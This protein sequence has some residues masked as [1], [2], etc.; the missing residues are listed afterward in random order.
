MRTFIQAKLHLWVC[1]AIFVLLYVYIM[2][3]FE[4]IVKSH[5]EI[6]CLADILSDFQKQII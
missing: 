4:N 1:C 6:Y 5:T 3:I 2:D